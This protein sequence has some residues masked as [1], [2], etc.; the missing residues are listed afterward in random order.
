MSSQAHTLH[1]LQY[2]TLRLNIL[3]KIPTSNAVQLAGLLVEWRIMGSELSF[4]GAIDSSK[5]DVGRCDS[6]KLNFKTP[7]LFQTSCGQ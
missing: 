6:F 4:L 5:R 3:F 1:T 7:V 2:S